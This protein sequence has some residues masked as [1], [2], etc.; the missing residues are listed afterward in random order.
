MTDTN[1]SL[2]PRAWDHGDR[3]ALL[4]IDSAGSSGSPAVT[5]RELLG[6]AQHM[7]DALCR[8]AGRPPGPQGLEGERVAFLLEPSVEWVVLEWGIWLCGG[9]AVPMALAHPPPELGHVIDDSDA[10]LVVASRDLAHRLPELAPGRHACLWDE[11]LAAVPE[12]TPQPPS[13]I[14]SERPALLV[15]TS[16]TTGKPKGVIITHGNLEA[17]IR[18]LVEAWGWTADDRIVEFLPLHHVHGVVNI[19][20]CALWSGAVC[21]ILPRFDATAVWRRL[22][23]GELTLLMAVPTI[24]HRLIQAWEAEPP[25]RRAVL[26]DAARG[27]RLMVSGSAALPV[28]VLER[29]REI[30]GHTLLERYGMTEIGM[31]LSNPLD[32]PRIP[33][34]VGSPLPRVQARLVDE[35]GQEVGDGVAG[36]IQIKGPTVFPGYWR[37]DD[38]TAEAFRDGW[39]LTGD[40][41]IREDGVYRILGRRS[42]DIL[43]SGGEKISALEIENVLLGHPAIRECAVVGLPSAEWGQTVAAAV[44]L[45]EGATLDLD[46]LRPWA[47]ERLARYKIPRRLQVFDALPRNALGK[48]TKPTLIELFD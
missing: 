40:Q 11:L 10:L 48:V 28:P 32:R 13:P 2:L 37:R 30:S 27:L 4:S 34:A 18:N 44:V 42:V 33:G 12:P 36:Q 16:G 47:Q 29:W 24:Y 1:P 39:F 35:A 20:A 41:A 7:A 19:L 46:T 14:P 15:Y 3:P 8:V 17:Q 6:R 26:S 23:S 22:E 21:E 31:G 38:A 9:I 43:K 25:E 45:T 5:Y